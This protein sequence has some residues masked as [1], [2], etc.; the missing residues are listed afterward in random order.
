MYMK[1]IQ[2]VVCCTIVGAMLFGCCPCRHLS[3]S[4]RDSVRVEVREHV[5]KIHDT[6][7]VVLPAE[8][9]HVRTRDTTATAET[10]TA[11]A[12]ASVCD[13][14]LSL[15]IVNIGKPIGVIVD[16]LILTRDSLIYRQVDNTVR[17]EVPRPLTWWQQTQIRGF[18]M[19][20]AL[21]LVICR[22]YIATIVKR[23]I[24]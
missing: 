2:I 6:V 11:R 9:E 24:Y 12:T 22:K 15:G 3:T 19:L 1:Q 21:L 7:S 20:L 5:I 17:V 18:Y 16:T 13:G 14:W 23:I 10:S 4:V 8:S